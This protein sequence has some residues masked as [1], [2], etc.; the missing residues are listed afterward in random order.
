MDKTLQK[1]LAFG[2]IVAIF[3]AGYYFL[4]QLPKQEEARKQQVE[5]DQ[6]YKET[7]AEY[8]AN[9]ERT[10]EEDLKACV[11]KVNQAYSKV[12]SESEF[13]SPGSLK[14]FEEFAQGRR[15]EC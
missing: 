2:I 14:S 7:L 6:H 9:V 12:I 4:Y 5:R 13:G 10:K 15:D 11:D 1:A 8:E 3:I